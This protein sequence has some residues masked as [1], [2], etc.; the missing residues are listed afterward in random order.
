MCAIVALCNGMLFDTYK[1]HLTHCLDT[2]SITALKDT[3][4]NAKLTACR[5]DLQSH[6]YI[7]ERRSAKIYHKFRVKAAGWQCI[8][9]LVLK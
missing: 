4:N 2:N 9:Y 7:L 1:E 6:P 5:I 8:G 3:I